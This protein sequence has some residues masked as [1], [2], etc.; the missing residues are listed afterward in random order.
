MVACKVQNDIPPLKRGQVSHYRIRP[1]EWEEGQYPD[2]R[3]I[4]IPVLCMQC[5]KPACMA[6]CPEDAISK[7]ADGI[8]ALD[9]SKCIACGACTQACPYGAPYLMETADKCDFC[10]EKRLDKGAQRPYCAQSCPGEAM[11]FCDL[12][13][14]SSPAAQQVLSGTAMPLCPEFGTRPRVYYVPPVWYRDRWA[15][16]AA[17]ETFKKALQ[18]REKDLIEA[19]A[20]VVN[21]TRVARSAGFM[22]G[23]LGVVA[24]GAMGLGASLDYLARRKQKVNE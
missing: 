4:F 17:N 23:P 8:V 1:V 15:S 24:V 22:T 20:P 21:L 12:A 14:A 5:D 7:R 13:D 9:Q 11:V 3:R 6:A 2:T 16:L 19:R 18:M 10:A